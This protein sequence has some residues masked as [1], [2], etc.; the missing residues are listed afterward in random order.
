MQ[1]FNRDRRNCDAQYLEAE[2][3]ILSRMSVRR[4]NKLRSADKEFL[5]TS[6]AKDLARFESQLFSLK[7]DLLRNVAELQDR[8]VRVQQLL[9]STK[10]DG[11]NAE[12]FQHLVDDACRRLRGLNHYAFKA[13]LSLIKSDFVVLRQQIGDSHGGLTAERSMLQRARKDLRTDFDLERSKLF[14][15]WGWLVSI[16][17]CVSRLTDADADFFDDQLDALRSEYAVAKTRP[18]SPELDGV[19]WVERKGT[20]MP[21]RVSPEDSIEKLL[22]MASD[23]LGTPCLELSKSHTG[24]KLRQG[25]RVKDYRLIQVKTPLVARSRLP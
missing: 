22:A 23:A 21:I 24:T 17:D 3:Q 2:K 12:R 19:V 1:Y 8:A 7:I 5:V 4:K 11:S 10:K 14:E 9:K 6:F 20:R 13:E 15:D 25:H 18:D 16:R